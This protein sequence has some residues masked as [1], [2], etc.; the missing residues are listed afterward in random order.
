MVLTWT[1]GCAET[2][3]LSKTG[4]CLLHE[5]WSPW[6]S[7]IECMMAAFGTRTPVCE[8]CGELVVMAL[9]GFVGGGIW[10]T[11][12]DAEGPGFNGLDGPTRC[13]FSAEDPPDHKVPLVFNTRPT[14]G[15]HTVR[16]D[17]PLPEG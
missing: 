7:H 11:E 3:S 16:V 17:A 4:P 9:Q 8:L 1:C 12:L 5:E 13:P 15:G 10:T 14:E 2:F 6:D